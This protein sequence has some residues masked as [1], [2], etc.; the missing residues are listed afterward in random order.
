MNSEVDNI[1]DFMSLDDEEHY[2]QAINFNPN[3]RV[4]IDEEAGFAIDERRRTKPEE[5]KLRR[6]V[7][8]GLKESLRRLDTKPR[9]SNSLLKEVR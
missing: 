9:P 4:T 8:M 3:R 7:V 2:A 5:N 6:T 1:Y